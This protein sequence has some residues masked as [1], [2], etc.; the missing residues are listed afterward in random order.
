MYLQY[1]NITF[2]NLQTETS[3]MLEYKEIGLTTEYLTRFLRDIEMSFAN[4]FF[5]AA[6][7]DLSILEK[8]TIKGFET[9]SF[10]WSICLSK[11]TSFLSAY[12]SITNI[13][14]KTMYNCTCVFVSG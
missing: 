8:T 5:E 6:K 11:Y 9:L 14:F 4:A 12:I 13:F 10:D 1:Y 3:H 2:F 7:E